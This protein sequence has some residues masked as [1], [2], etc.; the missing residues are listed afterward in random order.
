[1]KDEE[2]GGNQ[3]ELPGGGSLA[4]RAKPVGGEVYNVCLESI[5]QGSLGK[6][7]KVC[8]KSGARRKKHR[9]LFGGH[10]GP[11]WCLD[12][13]PDWSSLPIPD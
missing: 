1:M 13:V 2:T 9:R 6:D 12:D 10:A 3:G 7:S 4:G 11:S 5:L 8:G